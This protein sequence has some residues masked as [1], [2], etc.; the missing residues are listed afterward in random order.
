MGQTVLY[1][2]T[3]KN[4]GNVPLTLSEFT[5]IY[6]DEQAGGFRGAMLAPGAVTIYSCSAKLTEIPEERLH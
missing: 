3:A 6:C 1:Q 4:T 2:I 5:D